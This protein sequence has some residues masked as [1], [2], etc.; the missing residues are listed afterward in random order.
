MWNQ[1]A[2]VP[3]WLHQ[4]QLEIASR[5]PQQATAWYLA[6]AW[7]VATAWYLAIAWHLV[8]AW[9]LAIAWHL[10]TEAPVWSQ[11]ELELSS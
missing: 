11:L 3:V 2:V 7:H 4:A 8:T 1:A 10:A 9:Y 5:Q 6:P